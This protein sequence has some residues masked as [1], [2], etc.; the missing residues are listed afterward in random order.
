MLADISP[1]APAPAA[2]T[3][4][5][6]NT[7][8]P[9]ALQTPRPPPSDAECR[10]FPRKLTRRI[11]KAARKT[12]FRAFSDS[13]LEVTFGCDAFGAELGELIFEQSWGHGF[14]LDLYRIRPRDEDAYEVTWLRYGAFGT[15]LERDPDHPPT[16]WESAA[17]DGATVQ[18]AIVPADLIETMLLELRAVMQLHIREIEPPPPESGVVR[19]G[20]V[21]TSSADFHAAYRFVD[22]AG[23]GQQDFWAG[24]Q[25]STDQ[26]RWVPI[27]L[28]EDAFSRFVYAEDVSALFVERVP[29]DADLDFFAERFATARD[30]GDEFGFW[31]VR[32]RMLA[33]ARTVG[34]ERLVPDLLDLLSLPG[35]YS[36]DRSRGVVVDILVRLLG[37]EVRYAEDGSERT[38]DDAAKALL[39]TC[40]RP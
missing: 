18:T 9:R 30:R 37:H 22:S 23:F 10:S 12:W 25:G 19:L 34:D 3:C 29:T 33:M 38:V 4:P 31:Y 27:A 1:S 14:S 35:G 6:A 16:A 40:D 8:P 17:R 36:E 39:S 7:T 15:R 5:A 21:G 2:D 26:D 28:A 24:Y 13:T 32:E 11:E 20:S